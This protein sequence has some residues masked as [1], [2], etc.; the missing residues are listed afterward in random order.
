MH[1]FTQVILNE[2]HLSSTV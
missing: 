2:N 1:H